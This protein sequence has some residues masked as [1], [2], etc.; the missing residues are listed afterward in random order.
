MKIAT[1]NS[2]PWLD[3]DTSIISAFLLHKQ[4]QKFEA[5]IS[6]ACSLG[7]VCILFSIVAIDCTE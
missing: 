3:L 5:K 7:C 1:R 4:G 6:R 2:A